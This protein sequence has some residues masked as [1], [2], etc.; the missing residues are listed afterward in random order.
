MR[1]G[2]MIL[3]L[4]VVWAGSALAQGSGATS[5]SQSIRP[6]GVVTKLQAGS[7]TLHTDAGPD[8]LIV[9]ADGVSFLRVPPGATNLDT[10]TK[11]TV[12]DINSG[13]RVLV[14]GRV[15]EDQKSV[16]ATSVI[17]MTKSDL[18]S[19]RE[20]EHLDWQRRGIGG[21]VQALNQETREITVITPSTKL[22]TLFN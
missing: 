16:V 5:S 4:M 22:M 21:T 10:A 9:L 2:F 1:K 11:I 15:S 7:L 20:A 18:A 3:P 12:S 13:D 6:I 14:R 19:A 17:V 8:L